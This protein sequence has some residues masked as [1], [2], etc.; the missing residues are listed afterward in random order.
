MARVK[1]REYI[2]GSG[3]DRLMGKQHL[4]TDRQ[5]WENNRNNNDVMLQA[6]DTSV[7]VREQESGLPWWPELHQ[8]TGRKQSSL[9]VQQLN[10]GR[11][12]PGLLIF[13][14]RP[15]AERVAWEN[16]LHGKM[17]DFTAQTPTR[18]NSGTILCREV[19]ALGQHYTYI[20][21]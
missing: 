5:T 13:S 20:K 15:G 6:P 9:R 1:Q 10:P 12:L 17:V 14:I 2:P 3:Q 7:P 16:M 19:K 8:H 11:E 4:E 18:T 21:L